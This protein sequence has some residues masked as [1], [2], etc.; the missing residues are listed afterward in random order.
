MH[1]ALPAELNV[2]TGHGIAVPFVDPAA[3]TY[4]ALHGPVQF[5]VVRPSACPYR[6]LAHSPAH[7]ADVRPGAFP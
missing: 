7:D 3:H 1:V 5:A 6:P 4:P 2:P